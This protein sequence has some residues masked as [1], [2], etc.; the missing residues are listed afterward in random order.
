MKDFPFRSTCDYSCIVRRAFGEIRRQ[1]VRK[2]QS[3]IGE[4]VR[5]VLPEEDREFLERQRLIQKQIGD[6][7]AA[8]PGGA[9]KVAGGKQASAGREVLAAK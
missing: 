9:T 3:K 2:E 1:R 7:M 8:G 5:A 6:A 4:C